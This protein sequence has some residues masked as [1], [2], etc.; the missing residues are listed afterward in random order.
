MCPAGIGLLTGAGGITPAL[1]VMGRDALDAFGQQATGG[2][3]ADVAQ[4]EDTDHPIGT[5]PIISTYLGHYASSALFCDGRYT[6]HKGVVSSE[7]GPGMYQVRALA[8]R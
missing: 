6:A 2:R 5:E 4:A 7:Q 8:R 3:M 1:V